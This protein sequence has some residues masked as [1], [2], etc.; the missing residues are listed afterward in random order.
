[1]KKILAILP[2]LALAGVFTFAAD[3]QAEE[4]K[5]EAAVSDQVIMYSEVPGGGGWD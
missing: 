2:I 5:Q 1:M 4:P 3:K